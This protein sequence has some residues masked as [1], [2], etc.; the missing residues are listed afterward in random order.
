MALIRV[1]QTIENDI[2]K[3]T[4]VND[5]S[6][7]TESDKSLMRKFGEPQINVGGTFG[8]DDDAFTLPDK[9][10]K[11]RS[12]LPY[13][14]EF[15]SRDT[16]FDTDTSIKVLSYRDAIVT[17]ITTAFTTLRD[18]EDTFTGEHVYNI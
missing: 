11:I 14:Q 7:L 2:W 3:L 15:D 5:I 16:T 1:Y 18:M 10:I 6:E 17:E 8:S 13:T 12:D 4:F 9:Y